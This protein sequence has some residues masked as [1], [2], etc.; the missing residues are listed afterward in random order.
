MMLLTG[1]AAPIGAERVTNRQA[2]AQVESNALRNGKPSANTVS[3]LHRFD[4]KEVAAKHPDEAVRRLHEKALATGDRDLLYALSEMS[5]V[6][7]DRIRRSVKP[8]DP[9]DARDYFLGSAVY[10]WLFLFSE[11]KDPPPSAFD[12][13]FREACDFYNHGLGRSLADPRGTNGSVR[14]ESAQRR[15]PVGAL[16]VTFETNALAEQFEQAE[17]ILP[18]D[19]YRVRGFSVRNRE[20]G[21]GTPLMAV[22]PM[23]PRW[24]LHPV[25]PGTA[26][27]QLNG[28]L[29]DLGADK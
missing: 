28:T 19:Q 24:G 11:G 23:D 5:Y 12:R 14:L 7:G 10:A 29:A 3:V 25:V 16:A 2:Y 9:R 4:L 8:W 21:L 15:L 26:L 27:L 1:C 17:W 6:A 22:K 20:A 13:R 18:A